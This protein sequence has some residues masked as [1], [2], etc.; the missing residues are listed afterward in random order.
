[1][2]RTTLFHLVPA[3]AAVAA[4]LVG[5]GSGEPEL[6]KE[7]QQ[8]FKGGAQGGRSDAAKSGLADF[9]KDFEAKHGGPKGPANVQAPGG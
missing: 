8:A 9:R 5:C 1:M 4:A 7:E 6:S 3:L 2:K